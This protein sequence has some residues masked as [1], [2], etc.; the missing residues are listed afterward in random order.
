M[1][2]SACRNQNLIIKSGLWLALALAVFGLLAFGI[3]KPVDAAVTPPSGSFTT[4]QQSILKALDAAIAKIDSAKAKISANTK[5]SSQ[6]KQDVLTMLNN[7]ESG[8]KNYETQVQAA[9]TAAEL[10]A[11]N[12]Q[13]IQY[14][15]D[16][17]PCHRLYYQFQRLL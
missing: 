15:K 13:V 1:D 12:Q 4:L 7:V 5:I 10:Q 14:L 3:M 8:L 9:T 16:N 11:I 6:T 2:F 17:K